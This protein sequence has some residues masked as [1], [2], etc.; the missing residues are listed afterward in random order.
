[1]SASL[2]ARLAVALGCVAWAGCKVGST[3]TADASD[4]GGDAAVDARLD[5]APAVTCHIADVAW[6]P[7]VGQ[8]LVLTTTGRALVLDGAGGLVSNRAIGDHAGLV[9][10]CGGS[11]VGC[12][13]DAVT[14]RSPTE[15]FVVV[16]GAI[17]S[18][19]AALATAGQPLALT[20]IPGAVAGPCAGVTGVCHLDAL[21]WRDDQ[22]R[23]VA[24]G[25][26]SAF[27]IDAA[28]A[29]VSSSSLRSIPTLAAGPCA[30]Q[31]GPCH[32]DALTHRAP[33][34]HYIASDHLYNLDAT[35][36]E[37][38]GSAPLTDFTGLA[39]VCN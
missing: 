28:G 16:N 23:F 20:S 29:L 22:Q 8:Y 33:V 24:V 36:G 34:L 12:Q 10:A 30:T 4:G 2:A 37:P 32:I 11:A 21:V 19:D 3:E 9:A 13:I 39:G 31:V 35:T 15:R 25:Q 18:L 17:Y 38:G 5:S 6:L 14:W 1:M 7:D 27:V 26:G